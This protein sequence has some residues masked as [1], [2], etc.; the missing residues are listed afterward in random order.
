MPVMHASPHATEVSF[1]EVLRRALELDREL[2]Y[3]D[4]ITEIEIRTSERLT[5]HDGVHV[6]ISDSDGKG[7]S[8]WYLLE[9]AD[10]CF[11]YL[12]TSRG[13]RKIEV[14]ASIDQ[15]S[16]L[17]K[18]FERLKKEAPG[19]PGVTAVR[20]LTSE[21]FSRDLGSSFS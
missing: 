2:G 12:T 1:H 13:A 21:D 15:L 17:L 10:M 18:E 9:A 11:L 20:D 4:L 3:R 5:F 19:S 6:E 7:E 16:A 14:S 8:R